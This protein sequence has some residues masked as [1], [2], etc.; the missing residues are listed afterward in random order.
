VDECRSLASGGHDAGVPG[1]ERGAGAATL[2]AVFGVVAGRR[3]GVESGGGLAKV[4]ERGEAW[5]MLT[6]PA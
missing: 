5:Q 3:G 6:L 4:P 2:G 1:C